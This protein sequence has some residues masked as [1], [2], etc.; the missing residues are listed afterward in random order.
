MKVVGAA[1]AVAVV[2]VAAV[3]AVGKRRPSGDCSRRAQD[4][5]ERKVE[6]KMEVV[7]A[8]GR[9]VDESKTEKKVIGAADEMGRQLDAL[10][11]AARKTIELECCPR[12]LPSHHHHHQS[13]VY[14]DL[15]APLGPHEPAF[16]SLEA[17]PFRPSPPASPSP[18][19]PTRQT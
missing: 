4:R 6:R 14:L 5:F 1:A 2:G 3:K 18:P 19:R 11:L 16:L 10:A 17:R 9:V 12:L 13:P 8:V 7:G 15:G